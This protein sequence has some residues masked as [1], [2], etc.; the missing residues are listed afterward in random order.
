MLGRHFFRPA[1]LHLKLRHPQHDE[2]TS[3]LYFDGGD[4]LH[5]DVANAVRDDLVAHL[6]RRD[7]PKG[8][9]TS[10]TSRSATI[11]SS[12]PIAPSKLA[13][14]PED[15]VPALQALD[16]SFRLCSAMRRP[17]TTERSVDCVNHRLTESE[18]TWSVK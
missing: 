14:A 10:P 3:Q 2:L 4:Y 7:D 16:L 18:Q 11:S 5:S 15:V 1:H 13:E 6:V 9:S 8:D 12:C 17:A